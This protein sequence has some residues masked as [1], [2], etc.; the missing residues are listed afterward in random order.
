M[1]SEK[2]YHAQIAASLRRQAAQLLADAE[3]L[4]GSTLDPADV[5]D[6]L[7]KFEEP[8]DSPEAA[9][10]R[11]FFETSNPVKA[12]SNAGVPVPYSERDMAVFD[13]LQAWLGRK[14]R[15][16]KDAWRRSGD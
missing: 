6:A 11:G 5:W 10:L 1:T 16:A 2:E 9:A 14:Y 15:F 4:E 13:A 12:L 8:G 3:S 7:P